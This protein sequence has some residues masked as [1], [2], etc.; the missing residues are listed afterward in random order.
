LF[1]RQKQVPSKLDTIQHNIISVMSTQRRALPLRLGTTPKSSARAIKCRF[2]GDQVDPTHK[3]TTCVNNRL[4]HD[5][6]VDVVARHEIEDGRKRPFALGCSERGSRPGRANA[7]DYCATAA[8]E[9]C[10][11][12]AA[13]FDRGEFWPM[14]CSRADA[15]FLNM[16]CTAS[17]WC[18]F[19]SIL[20]A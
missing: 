15:K 12:A 9:D 17:S 1:K 16:P 5:P 14:P 2:Y 10:A 7:C 20:P 8:V 19:W 13:D 4:Q 11:T 18:F 6:I 3:L